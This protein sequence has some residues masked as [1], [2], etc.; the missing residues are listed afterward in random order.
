MRAEF[1]ALLDEVAAAWVVP[2]WFDH[3]EKFFGMA[4][5]NLRVQRVMDEFIPA[6]PAPLE[7][8]LA[9]ARRDAGKSVLDNPHARDADFQFVQHAGG[10]QDAVEGAQGG[11][12]RGIFELL[13]IAADA[14]Q[15]LLK[16]GVVESLFVE[17]PMLFD[18]IMEDV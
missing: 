2:R 10:G 15:E 9:D 14:A 6:H 7:D 1:E 5:I 8:C 13:R 4:L 12:G 11:R 16:G 3:R 18:Q 17:L